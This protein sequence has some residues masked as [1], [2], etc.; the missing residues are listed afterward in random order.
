[1]GYLCAATRLTDAAAD[2]AE[3]A[4][5]AFLRQMALRH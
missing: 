2:R 3:S 5:P 1:M 4:I